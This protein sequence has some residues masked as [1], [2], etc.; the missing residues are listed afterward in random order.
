MDLQPV[1][2][3][4]LGFLSDA[5]RAYLVSGGVR[6]TFAENDVLLRQG[7]PTD[8]VLVVVTGWV[9][10]FFTDPD[11]QEIVAALR[12][13]GDVVGERAALH[14]WDRTA[15]VQA[16]TPVAVIQLSRGQLMECLLAKPTIAIG[17]IKQ[18]SHR[19]REAEATL[20]EVTTLD[21]SRRVA[22]YLLRLAS[23]H[24]IPDTDGTALGLPLS[25]QEIANRVGASLRTVARAIALLRERGIISTTRPRRIVIMLPDVLRSFAGN[26]S[27]DNMSHG[28]WPT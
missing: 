12:G 25:Q 7:D 5:D 20:L 24:G 2:G 4:L 9:R 8:H 15:T 3:S 18:M 22:A 21:V 28:T 14:D 17:M 13:P 10:I 27:A 16:L 19:L 1:E 6:R 11:G 26:V 23:Q